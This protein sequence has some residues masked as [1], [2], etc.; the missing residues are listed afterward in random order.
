LAAQCRGVTLACPHMVA[1]YLHSA[2]DGHTVP[3][4]DRIVMGSDMQSPMQ[5]QPRGMGGNLPFDFGVSQRIRAFNTLVG[6]NG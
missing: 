1:Q 2:G 4:F 5:C 3:E 6:Q